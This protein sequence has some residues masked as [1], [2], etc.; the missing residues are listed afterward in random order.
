MLFRSAEG[1]EIDWSGVVLRVN[2]NKLE[3]AEKAIRIY[4]AYNDTIATTDNYE[5]AYKD[6]TYTFVGEN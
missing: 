6:G 2:G 1:E 3:F 4:N 5:I